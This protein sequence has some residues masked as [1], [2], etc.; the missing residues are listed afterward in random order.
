MQRPPVQ[1]GLVEQLH[2]V[3][4]RH[5][6]FVHRKPERLLFPVGVFG[7]FGFDER[8]R[9]YKQLEQKLLGDSRVYVSY[10]ERPIRFVLYSHRRHADT[11]ALRATLTLDA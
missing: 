8:S 9:L 5:L 4:H 1:R 10:E 7:D 2:G 3:R 6:V 11:G